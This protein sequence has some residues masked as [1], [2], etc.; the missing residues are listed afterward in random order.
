M[1]IFGSDRMKAMMDRLGM[2]D[3]EPIENRV[4]SSSLEAAQRKVEGHNFDIRKHLLDYDDV[5]N[6]HRS[7][8][9]KKRREILQSALE[10]TKEGERPL[11]AVMLEMIEG[12]FEDMAAVYTM[13]EDPS[14][15]EIDKLEEAMKAILPDQVSASGRL[16]VK[17]DEL[18]GREDLALRRSALIEAMMVLAKESYERVENMVGDVS[19]I[20]EV[21]KM[22]LLR[23]IDDLW[24]DHLETMDHLRHGIGLQGYGQHDPLVEYK[25]EAFR[26]F[27][28]LMSAINQRVTHT[29]FKVQIA[30][31]TAE[32]EVSQVPAM[33]PATELSPPVKEMKKDDPAFKHVGRNDLCPCGS[34]KKFKRCHGA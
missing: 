10:P 17:K 13:N 25:K 19:V 26:L 30:R 21:E 6:K 16:I 12:T 33:A 29:I 5:L 31:E 2:P 8:V 14:T 7:V 28:Q 23:S 20:H 11:K 34:G 24:I 27:S 22:V 15:W 32:R 18:Q 1:R 3:D 9:Y 4:L